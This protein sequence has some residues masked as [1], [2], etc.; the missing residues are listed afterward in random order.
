MPISIL[1]SAVID[2]DDLTHTLT[3]SMP[4]SGSTPIADAWEALYT[5]VEGYIGEDSEIPGKGW[6]TGLGFEDISQM[7]VVEA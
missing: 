2:K 1:C 3:R 6:L 5:N 4:A 7:S